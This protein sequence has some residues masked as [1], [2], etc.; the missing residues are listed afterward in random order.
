V[1]AA[2][3]ET[4]SAGDAF[5]S[6]AGQSVIITGAGG[7][8]GKGMALAFARAGARVVVA[9]RRASTGDEVA[10]QIRDEGGE[11]VCVRCDVTRRQDV[12]AAVN[13]A[14]TRF[15]KLD[16]FIHNATSASSSEKQELGDLGRSEWGG[17]SGVSI[18]ALWH[19]SR[20]AYPG[21]AASRGSFLVIVSV[22]G[23][24]GS[25]GAPL[26]STVK[27]AQRG[28]VKSLGREWAPHGIR[29]NGLGPLATTPGAE[30]A[31]TKDPALLERVLRALPAG[32][33]GTAETDIAPVAMFLCSEAGRYVIGQT[34]LAVGGRYTSL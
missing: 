27:G 20:A 19:C 18:R 2:E 3:N 6:V 17:H 7:G 9:A 28:F 12:D 16:S 24:E 29:V 1:T 23:M 14:V 11:A 21:L 33:L 8:I 34:V 5:A 31:F 26:Y 25:L 13:V 32:R 4:S 22:V 15:G 10:A 30:E